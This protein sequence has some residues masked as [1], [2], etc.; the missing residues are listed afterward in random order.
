[1]REITGV[2][3]LIYDQTCAAEKRRRRKRGTMPDPE[4]RVFINERVCEGCGDCSV[5]SN[6]VSVVPLETEFG[7][8][9]AIDQSS[10]NKDYSCVKGF[11]PSFVSVEG[12]RLKK[13]ARASLDSMPVLPD[14]ALPDID[15]PFGILVTGIG[16]TGVVTI[17]AL[18]GMA[19]HLEG[20]GCSVLDMT[21]LAQKNGAVVSHVRVAD[22]PEQLHATRI[23]AGEA[24]LVLGCDILTGVGYDALAKMQ[25]GVTKALVNSALVMPA[26]FTRNPDLAFPVGSMEREIEDAVGTGDAEFLDAT[27]LATGLMGDSIATN[28]F[29]VGFAYQRG[30]LPVG[31]AA[32][33]R[34]IELNGTAV[35]SNK[36]SFRWG[37]LAA[38]DPARVSAA[39]IPSAKPDSQRLSESLDESSR[40]ARSS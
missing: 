37:R 8:K 18:I 17:G 29:M 10:C 26:G 34:A 13:P 21:G 35:E 20:K 16:G 1:M 23:A 33:L 32:L 24:K 31:E 30:L 11:C 6:C 36:Q 22:S 15:E 4:R 27:K 5:Q 9:R 14:P 38:V 3:V 19:A 7:R 39:A 12:G 2:T 25:K 40:V 28:L